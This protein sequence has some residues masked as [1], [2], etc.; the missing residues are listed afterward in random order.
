MPVEWIE[1]LAGRRVQ[2]LEERAL[3]HF[4]E[5]ERGGV[6]LSNLQPESGP[7]AAAEEKPAWAAE[8]RRQ[9]RIG[10]GIAGDGSRAVL[11]ERVV[12]GGGRRARRCPCQC[13]EGSH[14]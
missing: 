4:V 3:P 8:P 5:V 12:M 1:A 13:H 7:G 2:S 6:Q 14:A 10:G 9:R 11:S